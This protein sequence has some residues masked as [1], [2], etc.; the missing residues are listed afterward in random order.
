MGMSKGWKAFLIIGGIFFVL[1]LVAVIGVVLILNSSSAPNVDNN[2]VLVL[3]VS[4]ALPDF[5][6]EDPAAKLLGF[7]QPQSLTALLTQLRKAKIDSRV[8]AIF[9]DVDFPQIGWGKAD[10]LRDA[11]LEF[12]KSGKP[13]YAYME[14]GSNKEYYIASAADKV[15]LPQ[16]VIFILM[17]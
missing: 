1:F 11:I 8:G 12:K 4:G 10:E 7:G 9:L 6:V 5:S 15:F 13:V 2:S 17:G 14:I 3:N 16:P